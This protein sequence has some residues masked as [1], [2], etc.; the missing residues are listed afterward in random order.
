M[1]HVIKNTGIVRRLDELGRITLPIELRRNLDIGEKDPIE[2]YVSEDTII[3]KKFAPVDT[4]TGST[5]DLIEFHGKMVSKKSV[6]EL[7][8]IAGII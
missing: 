7:A 8:K 6:E 1:G 3:L 5:D 2:I 4:F